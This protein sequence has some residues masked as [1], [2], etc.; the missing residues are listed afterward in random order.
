MSQF[1]IATNS[2]NLP[3]AVPTSFV[4]DNGTAIPAVNILNVNGGQTNANNDNGIRVIANPDL[5]NNMVV[6][7][8]NR[9]TGTVTT[10]D[11]TPTTVI[12][13]SLGATPGVYLVEGDLTAY[14]VT[15]A[16]GSSYT[17]IG[18][19]LT[20]GVVATEISVENKNIFEPLAMIAADFNVGVT[21]NSAFLEVIGIAGKTINW[22]ALFT[23]RFVG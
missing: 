10:T 17:F 20:N 22:N 2:G 12:T 3:P 1:F 7:L 11:A 16:S 5:S 9:I 23:Y 6:Q 18:A 4:T 13:L 19:A 8:T 15:D 14:N 21:G